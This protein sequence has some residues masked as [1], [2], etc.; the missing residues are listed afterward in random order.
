MFTALPA[1]DNRVEQSKETQ[2]KDP[3]CRQIRVYNSEA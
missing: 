2:E 3:M 1:L